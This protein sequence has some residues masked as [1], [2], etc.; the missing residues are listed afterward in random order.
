VPAR[1]SGRRVRM[2]NPKSAYLYSERDIRPKWAFLIVSGLGHV[3]GG[4]PL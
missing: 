2:R 1:L 4:G 3:N